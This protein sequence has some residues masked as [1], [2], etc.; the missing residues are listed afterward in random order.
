MNSFLSSSSPLVSVVRNATFNPTNPEKGENRI[1]K[2]FA[3]VVAFHGKFKL[4]VSDLSSFSVLKKPSWCIV[5]QRART[6]SVYFLF[7]RKERT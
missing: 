6:C 7:C 3:N 1:T 2:G 5:S 4:S